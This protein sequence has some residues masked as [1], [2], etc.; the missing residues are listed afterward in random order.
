MYIF[1]GLHEKA[2]SPDLIVSSKQT[3]GVAVDNFIT[4]TLYA[5]KV[6]TN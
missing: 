3:V 6:S 5:E 4:M 1:Y 2:K